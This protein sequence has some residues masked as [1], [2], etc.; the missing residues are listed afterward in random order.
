MSIRVIHISVLIVTKFQFDFEYSDKIEVKTGV[1]DPDFYLEISGWPG[2]VTRHFIGDNSLE[3]CTLVW[4]KRTI[5]RM[6]F[7]LSILLLKTVQSIVIGRKPNRMNNADLNYYHYVNYTKNVETKV[8]QA[9]D[10]T[11][12]RPY[13]VNNNI[14]LEKNGDLITAA[15]IV[16]NDID[17]KHNEKHMAAVKFLT[18]NIEV[19]PLGIN[20]RTDLVEGSINQQFYISKQATIRSNKNVFAISGIQYERIYKETARALCSIKSRNLLAIVRKQRT[21]LSLSLKPILISRIEKD[22][23]Q[24]LNQQPFLILDKAPSSRYKLLRGNKTDKNNLKKMIIEK[25]IQFRV[26][27][28]IKPIELTKTS[29]AY[30]SAC[31]IIKNVE[32]SDIGTLP[33]IPIPILAALATIGLS[34]R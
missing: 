4:D 11:G 17:I 24:P 9:I 5:E 14:V 22:F 12:Q 15:K 26:L 13:L 8:G 2:V 29:L 31:E 6:E 34:S 27:Q 18:S 7:N 23:I 25:K 20:L 30:L 10:S 28:T 33:N 21:E 3:L 1:Q 16:P 32:Y 19:F